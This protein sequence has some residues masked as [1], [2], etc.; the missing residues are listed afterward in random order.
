MISYDLFGNEIKENVLKDKFGIIPFS[1]LDTKTA[2]WKQRKE[3]WV[4][5]GI[6]SELGREEDLLGFKRIYSKGKERLFDRKTSI[7]DPV[8]CELMYDWFCI[9]NG[10]VLDCFAGGSV[11]GITA[12]I[13]DLEYTGIEIRPEQV[14]SNR[15]QANQICDGISPKWICGDSYDELDNIKEKFD[16]LFTC[17]PYFDL[18][19]YSEIK[20]DISNMNWD[21]FIERYELILKK[22]CDLLKDNRFFC[23]VVGDVRDKER[24]INWY[25]NLT[26]ETKRIIINAGLHFYNEI[27]LLDNIGTSAMRVDQA[28]SKR[29][30]VKTHQNIFIFYKGNDVND[31]RNEFN[32]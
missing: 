18:E 14:E 19:K 10:K 15:E 2:E 26:G 9:K 8:L 32:K 1:V 27:I 28:F 11:R 6:K 23:I 24:T 20:G 13:K 3:R 25:R 7:F 29:K 21:T 16:F 30:I 5:L 4:R 22:S 17:P 31:I 12:S